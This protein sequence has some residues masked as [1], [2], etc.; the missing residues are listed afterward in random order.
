MYY[1]LYHIIFW[2]Q[3]C[4]SHKTWD[5]LKNFKTTILKYISYYWI[6]NEII[7]PFHREWCT[8]SCRLSH[9]IAWQ[10]MCKQNRKLMWC[11]KLHWGDKQGYM[12]KW[13]KDVVN[14]G[15]PSFSWDFKWDLDAGKGLLML[16][17]QARIFTLAWQ[18]CQ[19]I[20]VYLSLTP[21]VA[22]PISNIN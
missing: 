6:C 20:Q 19:Q 2:I 11:K 7:I 14:M 22:I 10:S 15:C 4:I 8:T 17:A 13:L 5:N 3:T 9:F 12:R 16:V 21:P 18:C 1:L